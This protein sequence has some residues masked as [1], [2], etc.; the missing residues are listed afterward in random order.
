MQEK[1][2]HGRLLNKK[3]SPSKD[4]HCLVE[5]EVSKINNVWEN[6]LD[7]VDH[8]SSTWIT[9]FIHTV[10][11]EFAIPLRKIKVNLNDLVNL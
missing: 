3:G 7:L 6:N 4:Q 2:W 9:D 10:N 5:F 1:E 8:F 11:K